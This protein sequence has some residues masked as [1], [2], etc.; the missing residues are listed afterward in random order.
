M[1][2]K[3]PQFLA[4]LTQIFLFCI[5]GRVLGDIFSPLSTYAEKF[6]F[7]LL[8]SKAYSG[9]AAGTACLSP[10]QA[11]APE[12]PFLSVFRSAQDHKPDRKLKLYKITSLTLSTGLGGFGSCQAKTPDLAGSSLHFPC[13][14]LSYC[15]LNLLAKCETTSS[16][17]VRH[18]HCLLHQCRQNA[19]FYCRQPI[20]STNCL[21]HLCH[22]EKPLY[23]NHYIN[24]FLSSGDQK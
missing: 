9:I 24:C 19:P 6:Q 15:L 12:Q 2:K 13:V 8:G 10:L 18:Y 23:G 20:V 4:L 5:S 21:K 14:T 16:I 1:E 11:Y 22:E 17:S 7:H 3:T